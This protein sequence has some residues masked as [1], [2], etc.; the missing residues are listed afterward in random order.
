MTPQVNKSSKM[1]TP[2]EEG[3]PRRTRPP[4]GMNSSNGNQPSTT[5]PSIVTNQG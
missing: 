2:A 5:L 4:S 3:M 1:G